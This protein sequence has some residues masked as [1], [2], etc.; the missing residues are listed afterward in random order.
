MPVWLPTA[1]PGYMLA[2]SVFLLQ[3]HT[4]KFMLLEG[5]VPWKTDI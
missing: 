1:S 4:P 2:R 5:G 3:P